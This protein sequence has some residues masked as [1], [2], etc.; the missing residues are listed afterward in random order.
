MDTEDRAGPGGERV[1]TLPTVMLGL[2]GSDYGCL[3]GDRGGAWSHGGGARGCVCEG[4]LV[5][6]GFGLNKITLRWRGCCCRGT[7]YNS[8]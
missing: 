5:N 3:G 1:L 6:A 4:G 8:T 7:L 2:G